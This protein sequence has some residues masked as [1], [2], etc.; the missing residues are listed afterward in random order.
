VFLQQGSLGLLA[1]V[2]RLILDERT[3]EGL[4]ELVSGK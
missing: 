2:E 3:L 4:I 1:V